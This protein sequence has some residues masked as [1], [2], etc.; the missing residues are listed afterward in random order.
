MIADGELFDTFIELTIEACRHDLTP[1]RLEHDSHDLGVGC[2]EAKRLPRAPQ[3]LGK[4]ISL[5]EQV[6]AHEI[7]HDFGDGW[8][9]DAREPRKLSTGARTPIS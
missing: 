1:T 2:R 7:R 5:L 9:A 3:T 4:G 6:R 8:S